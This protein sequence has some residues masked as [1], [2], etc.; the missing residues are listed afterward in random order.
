[1]HCFQGLVAWLAPRQIAEVYGVIN[2]SNL[3]AQLAEDFGRIWVAIHF[4]ALVGSRR[5]VSAST[6]ISSGVIL[7]LL[8][9]LKALL[10][11]EYF[12]HTPSRVTVVIIIKL[13]SL[14]S[15]EYGTDLSF[16]EGP[17]AE[18]VSKIIPRED[19]VC[20]FLALF[21]SSDGFFMY[22][23][24]TSYASFWGFDAMEDDLTLNMTCLVGY[25]LMMLGVFWLALL[26]DIEI[27]K[28]YGVSAIV[29]FLATLDLAFY[30]RDGMTMFEL[31]EPA[32]P[33]DLTLSFIA[34]VSSEAWDVFIISQKKKASADPGSPNRA[35]F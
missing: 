3:G 1:M 19:I 16:Q 22:F 34:I 15:I 29:Y 8:S 24:P 31:S 27:W 20:E 9:E 33:V 18:T 26:K 11:D 13:L 32:P 12:G 10:N 21:V 4:G 14:W 35:S 7:L 25:S 30:G 5:G 2:M 23:F 6:V 28:A 17:L